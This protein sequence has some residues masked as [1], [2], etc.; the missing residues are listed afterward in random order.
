MPEPFSTIPAPVWEFLTECWSAYRYLR[1]SVAQVCDALS[2]FR[3]IEALP[4]V[5]KLEVQSINIQFAEPKTRQFSVKFKY[6]D[7]NYMTPLTTKT[8]VG[9][10]HTWFVFVHPTLATVTKPRT[11]RI[12]EPG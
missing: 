7:K 4:T 10:E 11:G 3:A 12:Q 9:H 8:M 5:L 6:G 2:R 1:P